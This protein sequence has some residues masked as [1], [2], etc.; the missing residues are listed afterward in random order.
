MP[1]SRNGIEMRVRMDK[2]IAYQE[3]EM[4]IVEFEED[5]VITSSGCNVECSLASNMIELPEIR[6]QNR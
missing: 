6:P 3:P 1:L 4:E 5:D 2:K